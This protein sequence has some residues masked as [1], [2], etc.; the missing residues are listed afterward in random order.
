MRY[1]AVGMLTA[2]ALLSSCATKELPPLK[3]LPV[4]PEHPRFPEPPK[5]LME[6]QPCVFLPAELC[7]PLKPSSN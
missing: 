7:R 5:D 6:R 3:V 2:L 1:K 4:T